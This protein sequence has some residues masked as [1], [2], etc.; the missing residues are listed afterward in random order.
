[1]SDA[2]LLADIGATNARF[3]LGD[4]HGWLSEPVVFSTTEF[5]D[6]ADLF[7]AVKAALPG[8]YARAVFAVA[9]PERAAGDFELT[10]TGLRFETGRCAQLLSCPVRV[11]NDF[12][13]V[14][15]ALPWLENLTQI[16]GADAAQY[17]TKA[18]LGP[19]SG[20][21]MA[22][23]HADRGGHWHVLSGEGGHADLA[24]ATHL[25]TE[26][27][28]VLTQEFGH[29]SLETVLC[30][31][32][33]VNLYEAMCVTWGMPAE[34]L[35][36]AQISAQGSSMESLVCHQTLETFFGLLGGAAGN[37]AL[38]AGARGGIYIAGGIVPRMT[39]FAVSS[40][41]RRRFDDKGVMRHFVEPIPLYLVLDENPGLLGARACLLQDSESLG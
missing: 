3:Q 28:S 37:L 10:N 19:G 6:V 32:G 24:P 27:W 5:S 34:P 35:T 11:V 7:A 18:V 26:L 31:S 29:V 8:P 25:E 15:A 2:C 14:A 23:L 13:A 17:H 30:G 36:A 1:M 41:L 16:G 39:D 22:I 12:Y 9:G 21:G 38:T 33:L 20:L 4:R 40:P